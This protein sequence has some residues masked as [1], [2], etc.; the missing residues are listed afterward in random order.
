M[1]SY[2]DTEWDGGWNGGWN[3]GASG[4]WAADEEE[5]QRSIAAYGQF[6]LHAISSAEVY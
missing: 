6:S 2:F 4:G 1:D 5:Y 3:G